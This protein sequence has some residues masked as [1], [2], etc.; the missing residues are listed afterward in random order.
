[1][2]TKSIF[3]GIEKRLGKLKNKALIPTAEEIGIPIEL[4]EKYTLK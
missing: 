1:M 3:K 2:R 4:I